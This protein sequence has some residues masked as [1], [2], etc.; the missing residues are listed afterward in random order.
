[1]SPIELHPGRVEPLR[2]HE[3]LPDPARLWIRWTPRDWPVPGRPW[4]D[5]ARNLLVDAAPPSPP[6][7]PASR[8]LASRAYDDVIGLPPV[9]TAEG[10]WRDAQVEALAE[11][12]APVVALRLPGE[13]RGA[14]ALSVYDLT[15]SLLRGDPDAACEVPSRAWALWPLIPGRTD[16][17][18]VVEA[19]LARLAEAGAAGV[20]VTVPELTSRQRRKL[21]EEAGE[22]AFTALFHGRTADERRFHRRVVERGL[23]VFPPR[24]LPDAPAVAGNRQL[25][26][27][28]F[29][30]G[31]L[32]RRLGRSVARGEAL[33]AAARNVDRAEH[34]LVRLARE[35]NLD[36]VTWLDADVQELLEVF[37]RQGWSPRLKDL[38]REY[39]GG[40]RS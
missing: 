25:A 13:R 16:G 28:L 30:L 37:L 20:Q 19:G 7:A 22:E 29:R 39:L 5:P 6:A 23:A 27:L 12:G 32:E 36:I 31:D 35:G 2:L 21:A 40:E 24:P 3:T 4:I 9:P 11:A 15:D 1:M 8:G 34:D 18:D 33:W 14:E 26:A 17:E 10:S 38:E